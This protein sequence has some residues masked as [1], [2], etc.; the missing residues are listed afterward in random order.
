MKYKGKFIDDQGET[1]YC[2]F[3]APSE[4]ALRKHL[5]EKGWQV[6]S[7]TRGWKSKLEREL[8]SFGVSPAVLSA[9]AVLVGLFILLQLGVLDWG[10][11]VLKKIGT[12][13]GGG[14]ILTVAVLAFLRMIRLTVK[15]AVREAVEQG[16]ESGPVQEKPRE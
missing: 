9:V 6:V 5:E 8:S 14:L 10:F 1:I 4:D 13:L 15:D 7:I 11:S 2:W 16:R 12:I 3:E